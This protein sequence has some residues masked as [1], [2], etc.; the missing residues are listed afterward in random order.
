[1]KLNWWGMVDESA[2][3]ILSGKPEMTRLLRTPICTDV[4]NF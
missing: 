2:H 1:M 3:K 4:R